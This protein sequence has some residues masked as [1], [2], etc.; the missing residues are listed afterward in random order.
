MQREGPEEGAHGVSRARVTV[1]DNDED[2]A[3]T[4]E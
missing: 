3:R 2:P 4:E 1:R